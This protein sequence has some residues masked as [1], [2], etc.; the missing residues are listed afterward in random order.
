MRGL[1]IAEETR[2]KNSDSRKY[3]SD[4]Q[5]KRFVNVLRASYETFWDVIS[6]LASPFR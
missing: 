2:D 6:A 3:L 1:N 5:G 4:Y